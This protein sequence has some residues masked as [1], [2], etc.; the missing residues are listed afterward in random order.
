VRLYVE[1]NRKDGGVGL[2]RLMT[3]FPKKVFEDED[4]EKP[5]E[6]LGLVPSAVLIVC[7]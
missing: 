3:S 5:L 4:Y 1:L 6:A 2:P 7:K